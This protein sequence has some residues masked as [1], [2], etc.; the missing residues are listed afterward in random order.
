[1]YLSACIYCLS[2]LSPINFRISQYNPL[3]ATPAA[4]FPPR[5]ST[6]RHSPYLTTPIDLNV[7]YKTLKTPFETFQPAAAVELR[8]KSPS[9]KTSGQHRTLRVATSVM[10]HNSPQQS[11]ISR[12]KCL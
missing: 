6:A 5:T 9:V 7:S 10:F 2:N 1:M 8:R 4:F 3:P 11:R 12:K